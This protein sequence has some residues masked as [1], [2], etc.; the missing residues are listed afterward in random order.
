MTKTLTVVC[1]PDPEIWESLAEIRVTSGRAMD[2][3]ED[4]C[5]R[6]VYGPSLG[7]AGF[8]YVQRSL[9]ANYFA[10]MGIHARP[11]SSDVD[12]GAAKGASRSTASL[13]PARP[14]P[15]NQRRMK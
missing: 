6:G 11:K 7:F 13:A 14:A 1:K 8:R 3:I 10:D 4:E 2:T 9:V 15:K 5:K 12:A